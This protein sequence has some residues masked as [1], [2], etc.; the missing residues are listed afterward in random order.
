MPPTRSGGGVRG[1]TA[2]GR[3][4][5]ASAV[6]APR[7]AHGGAARTRSVIPTMCEGAKRNAQRSSNALG[8]GQ[9]SEARGAFRTDQAYC[10]QARAAIICR[11][12]C[13][14]DELWSRLPAVF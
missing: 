3:A 5:R 14:G 7:H 13:V 4:R 2:P 9:S 6:S 12:R 8:G 1:P 11:S 10:N